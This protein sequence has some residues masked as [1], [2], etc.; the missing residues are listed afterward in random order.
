LYKYHNYKNND[1]Y[2]NLLLI[3]LFFPT[4]QQAPQVGTVLGS[5]LVLHN[6][7]FFLYPLL[8]CSTVATLSR[9]ERERIN[10]L[11]NLPP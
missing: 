5:T 7:S 6:N 4:A 3:F 8:P 2:L 10:Y 9:E 11:L 1:N